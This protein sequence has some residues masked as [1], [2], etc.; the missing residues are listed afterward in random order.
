MINSIYYIQMVMFFRVSTVLNISD[1]PK[2]L[3]ILNFTNLHALKL[4]PIHYSLENQLFIFLMIISE[5]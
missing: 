5:F 2:C 3:K 1:L 4:L